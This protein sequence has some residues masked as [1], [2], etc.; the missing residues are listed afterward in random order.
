MTTDILDDIFSEDGLIIEYNP[1]TERL[2]SVVDNDGA[3]IVRDVTLAEAHAV[4]DA[5]DMFGYA[6][7]YSYIESYTHL[8]SGHVLFS[9]DVSQNFSHDA[10]HVSS[11][12]ELHVHGSMI[13]KNIESSDAHDLI[14]LWMSDERY[15]AEYESN[16]SSLADALPII[17]DMLV[18]YPPMIDWVIE[19]LLRPFPTMHSLIGAPYLVVIN[20]AANT[21]AAPTSEKPNFDKFGRRKVARLPMKE[22]SERRYRG[23]PESVLVAHGYTLLDCATLRP[24][25]DGTKETIREF[26]ND[27]KT[28]NLHNTRIVKY[29]N[30]WKYVQRVYRDGFTVFVRGTRVVSGTKAEVVAWLNAEHKRSGLL[31]KDAIIVPVEKNLLPVVAYTIR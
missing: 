5:N 23:V 21:A 25:M 22:S 9:G 8:A 1:R 19:N 13:Y 10:S 2:Y 29:T 26:F 31:P 15:I 27:N 18:A 17:N 4:A 24:I 16:L 20:D 11:H 30:V 7:P 12:V 3:T 14:D 6:G 28:Y